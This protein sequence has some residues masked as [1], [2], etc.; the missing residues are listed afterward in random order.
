MSCGG[1]EERIEVALK[2]ASTDDLRRDRMQVPRSLMEQQE[3]KYG[4]WTRKAK[5]GG[6]DEGGE[7]EKMLVSFWGFDGDGV[8]ER[9]A[10]S[11][12]GVDHNMLKSRCRERIES[13]RIIAAPGGNDKVEERDPKA[14]SAP[15]LGQIKQVLDVESISTEYQQQYSTG[16]KENQ[17]LGPC[18]NSNYSVHHALPGNY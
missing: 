11:G 17:Y 2:V 13:Y 12:N 3:T 7:K 8:P 10:S 6:V 4:G 15:D 16:A 14:V 9:L 18:N 1:L 5:W